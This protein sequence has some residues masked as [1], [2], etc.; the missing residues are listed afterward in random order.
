LPADEPHAE[1]PPLGAYIDYYLV[2]PTYTPVTLDIY[3]FMGNP[4]RHFSSDTPEPKINLSK[5][6]STPAWVEE[7]TLLSAAVGAHRFVWD[8][9]YA[10]PQALQHDD[11]PAGGLWVVPGRYKLVLSVNGKTYEQTLTVL[12]DPRTHISSFSLEH[13]LKFAQQIESTRVQVAE[14]SHSITSLT[15]QLQLVKNKVTGQLADQIATLVLKL[16]AI[17]GTVPVNPDDSV[18]RPPASLDNL[19]YLGGALA[20]LENAVESVDAAPTPDARTGFK[21]QSKALE[22]VMRK[23]RQLQLVDL[24]Q[25]N[26]ALQEA[27]QPALKF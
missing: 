11:Q 1:N 15:K 8:L 27:G 9:R 16:D 26:T 22:P 6:E 23:W 25:M 2:K 7:P 20:D 24:P 14:A 10:L 4:V 19:N 5:I 3:N 12:K 18:G 13:Q 17:D 21:Q